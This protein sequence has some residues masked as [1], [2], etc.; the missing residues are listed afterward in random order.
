MR[1]AFKLRDPLLDA[2]QD[3]A[4]GGRVVFGDI[5]DN[6]PEVFAGLWRQRH[7]H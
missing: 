7:F 4:G 5:E 3:E 6:F 2:I 1:I